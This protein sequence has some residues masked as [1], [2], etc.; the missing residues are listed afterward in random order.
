MLSEVK[1]ERMELKKIL[2]ERGVSQHQMA[3]DLEVNVTTINRYLNG[4]AN[5]R[6]DDEQRVFDYLG[7]DKKVAVRS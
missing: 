1:R 6:P 4:W 5:L 7:F 2:L 3:A